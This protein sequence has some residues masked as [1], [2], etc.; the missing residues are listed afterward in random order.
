MIGPRAH[1][2][3]SAPTQI[4]LRARLPSS[5]LK[6]LASYSYITVLIT[7][8]SYIAIRLNSRYRAPQRAGLH[9]L[10]NLCYS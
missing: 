9:L 8:T 2:Q 4:E 7:Q 5:A 1:D 6:W 10:Y 3:G